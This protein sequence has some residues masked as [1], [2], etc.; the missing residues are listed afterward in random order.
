MGYQIVHHLGDQLGSR[1]SVSV[2]DRSIRNV[3]PLKTSDCS[4]TYPAYPPIVAPMPVGTTM[5][6]V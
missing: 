4:S 1:E 6:A 5:T 3:F 2:I